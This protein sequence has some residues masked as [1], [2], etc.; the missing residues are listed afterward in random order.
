M[1]LVLASALIVMLAL[2]TISIDAVAG[3]TVAKTNKKQDIFKVLL[4]VD[5]INHIE[6]CPVTFTNLPPL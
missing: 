4:T 1:L 5:G 3:Q 2:N 6:I